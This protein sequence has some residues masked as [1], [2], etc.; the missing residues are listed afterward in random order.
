M[1]ITIQNLPEIMNTANMPLDL[2]LEPGEYELTRRIDDSFMLTRANNDL[3]R[4]EYIIDR[5]NIEARY[6]CTA[7]LPVRLDQ[8]IYN[9]DGFEESNA[10]A[11]RVL[12]EE[13]ED[14]WDLSNSSYAGAFSCAFTRWRNVDFIDVVLALAGL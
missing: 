8:S 10:E 12:Y 6:R 1:S 4:F 13:L 9:R 5:D 14:L 2:N 3:C 11:M 7:G